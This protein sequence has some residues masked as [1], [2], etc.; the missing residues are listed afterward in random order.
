MKNFCTHQDACEEIK[1][2]SIWVSDISLHVIYAMLVQKKQVEYLAIL[3]SWVNKTIRYQIKKPVSGSA[4]S[5]HTH[6]VLL[7]IV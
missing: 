6:T 3:N 4:N 1:P 7:I 5:W 2:F